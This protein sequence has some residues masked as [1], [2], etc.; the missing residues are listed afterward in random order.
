MRWSKLGWVAAVL[1]FGLALSACRS[2]DESA[3]DTT[4]PTVGPQ[5]VATTPAPESTASPTKSAPTPIPPVGAAEETAVVATPLPTPASD[6]AAGITAE[7]RDIDSRVDWAVYCPTY[8][9]PG[10]AKELIGG[11]NPLEIR[12]VNPA[13]GSRIYFVQGVGMGLSAVTSLVR[14][15]G[16]LVGTVP[17]DDL[18]GQLFRSLPEAEHAPFTALLSEAPAEGPRPGSLQYV[19]GYGVSEDEMRAIGAGMRRL[20]T[21][22]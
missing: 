4:Q 3:Q 20:D 8:L 16:E 21:I 10:Y 1:V 5:A 15:E 18:D 9:P 2:G 13:T 7:L 17:Y 6:C 19:E 12:I 11:P 14:N 22:P